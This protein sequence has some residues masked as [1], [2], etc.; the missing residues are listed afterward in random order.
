MVEIFAD[1]PPGHAFFD[2]FSFF[3]SE[4][5]P[6]YQQLL[7]RTAGQTAAEMRDEDRFRLRSLPFKLIPARHR[8]GLLNDDIQARAL[9]AREIFAATLPDTL[10]GEVEFFDPDRYNRAATLQDNILF[11]KVSYGEA[12]AA[13]KLS[14][15]IGEVLDSL[16]LRDAVMVAGLTHS[17]GVAGAR[18][19]AAQ[20]QKVNMARGLIKQPDLFVVNEGISNL[21]GAAQRRVLD[22]VLGE[23]KGHGVIWSLHRPGFAR[24]FDHVIVMKSGRVVEQ[25]SFAELD[26]EGS[27]LRDLLESE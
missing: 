20:R 7:A 23:M 12:N 26:R 4:E 22:A 24:N 6:E 14:A 18:L 27:T 19:S 17:V 8:L 3:G 13:G 10:R 11:G 25:G 21:D 9:K 5:M 16:S 2:Q 15:M 1:L